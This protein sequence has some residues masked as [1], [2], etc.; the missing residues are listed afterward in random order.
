M[1]DKVIV[2]QE[3]LDGITE[4]RDAG[5]TNMFDARTM[6]HILKVM[7]MQTAADWVT[8]NKDEYAKGMLYGFE[9]K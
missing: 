5:L 6:A 4:V 7:G 3:V 2:T 9:V 8:N 1:E